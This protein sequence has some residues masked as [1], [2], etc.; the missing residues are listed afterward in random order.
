MTTLT[1]IQDQQTLVDYEPTV[2][3]RVMRVLYR[4]EQR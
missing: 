4:L 2:Q 1:E 3:D